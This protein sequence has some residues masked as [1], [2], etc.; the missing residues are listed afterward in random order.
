MVQDYDTGLETSYAPKHRRLLQLRDFCRV[1][2]NALFSNPTLLISYRGSGKA[3]QNSL[4]S[5]RYLVASCLVGIVGTAKW[6]RRVRVRV[7]FTSSGFALST[8]WAECVPLSFGPRKCRVGLVRDRS[9]L[10]TGSIS[11]F[12]ASY[13]QAFVCRKPELPG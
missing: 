12:G 10:N 8:L 5:S 3:G 1:V 7:C 6:V 11:L 4:H 9:P 13:G 2:D